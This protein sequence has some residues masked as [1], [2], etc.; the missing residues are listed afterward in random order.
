MNEGILDDQAIIELAAH[1][2][3]LR[4][5][6]SASHVPTVARALGWTMESDSEGGIDFDTGL[7]PSSGSVEI[8][9][10]DG[11]SAV[12]APV[13]SLIDF[14]MLS[15][16][17]LRDAFAHATG[18]LTEAFGDPT[19]R[20]PG[21]SPEVRWRGPDSTLGLNDTC[22]NVEIFSARNDYLDDLD[23]WEGD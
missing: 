16:A 4:W 11:V 20:L 1:L 10:K 6:W 22:T 5:P 14:K 23:H 13:T 3:D 21:P 18:L 2:R 7:G 9:D 15:R 12:Y 8:D 19:Q 17:W